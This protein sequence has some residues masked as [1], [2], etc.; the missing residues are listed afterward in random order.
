MGRSRYLEPLCFAAMN[1]SKMKHRC[2][3]KSRRD[4]YAISGIS[5]SIYGLEIWSTTNRKTCTELA[6]CP[7][8]WTESDLIFVT[9]SRRRLKWRPKKRQ[10][11]RE[12]GDNWPMSRPVQI[13]WPVNTSRCLIVFA[14]LSRVGFEI[15]SRRLKEATKVSDN[16]NRLLKQLT[17]HK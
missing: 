8:L 2:V 12:A 16:D 13:V 9:R 4:W 3:Q 14:L 17:L 6:M 11:A 15:E 1:L 10:W 5:W 7:R